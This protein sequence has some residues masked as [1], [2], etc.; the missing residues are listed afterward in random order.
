M[1]VCKSWLHA[2]H[3]DEWPLDWC[4]LYAPAE[5][6]HYDP[7]VDWVKRVQPAVRWLELE[8]AEG[9][10]PGSRAVD[11]LE[12]AVRALREPQVRVAAAV[13]AGRARLAI[14]CCCCAVHCSL[15]RRRVW[16][17]RQQCLP[18][19]PARPGWVWLFSR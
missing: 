7:L 8:V 2:L 6:G 4:N 14:A 10:E 11:A 3:P 5:P 9:L 12:E 13:R 19:P 16:A 1:A 18:R 15:T 17:G